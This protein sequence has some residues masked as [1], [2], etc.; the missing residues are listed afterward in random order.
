[1]SSDP[2][3]I[4]CKIIGKTIPSAI[5]YEDNSVVAFEDVHPQA[6]V[7][8]LVVPKKHIPDIHSITEADR[9]LVGHLFWAA[10]KIATERGLDAKGYRM[11]I[12][13]G[14]GAGQSVFHIHLHILSGR[15]F[16]WPPG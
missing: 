6:P 4:F 7:H 15:R 14:A 10:K 2:N 5:V 12:N 13:N 3:C 11:V 8:L 1:M 16:S 9:E